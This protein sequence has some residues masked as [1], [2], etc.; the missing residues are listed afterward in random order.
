MQSFESELRN[1]FPEWYKPV[2]CQ[3]DGE[4][5]WPRRVVKKIKIRQ[6]RYVPPIILTMML[7]AAYCAVLHV[8]SKEY[9]WDTEKS[10]ANVEK[11]LV[12]VEEDVAK[13]R[14]AVRLVAIVVNEDFMAVQ[15]A[16][17]VQ[18]MLFIEKNWGI[19]RLPNYLQLSDEEKRNIT[20]KYIENRVYPNEDNPELDDTDSSVEPTL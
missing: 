19:K 17:G 13:V 14:D 1:E 5:I 10:V 3:T 18:N 4:R 11:E 15:R 7:L 9:H 6:P 16:T 12:R 2:G 20:Q 8:K